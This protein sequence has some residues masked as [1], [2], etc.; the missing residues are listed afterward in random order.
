MSNTGEATSWTTV[1]GSGTKAITVRVTHDMSGRTAD[2]TVTTVEGGANGS[3]GSNGSN[4]A[5]GEDAVTCEAF[6]VYADSSTDGG[7][8]WAIGAT[9]VDRVLSF[10]RL[11]SAIATGT[12]RAALTLS[13]TPACTF[14]LVSTSGESLSLS[15]T[16]VID[17][18]GILSKVSQLTHTASGAKTG[19][20][21]NLTAIDFG[22]PGKG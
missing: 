1:S 5:D 4:G 11:G 6:D 8:T 2:Q 16:T 3:N 15:T 12:I 19:R 22:S 17:S 10:Y 20:T 21:V 9:T 13:G 14:S 7:I 18:S